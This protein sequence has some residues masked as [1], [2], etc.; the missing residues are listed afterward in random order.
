MLAQCIILSN[1]VFQPARSD[2]TPISPPQCL[3]PACHAAYTRHNMPLECLN[4]SPIFIHKKP[5]IFFSAPVINSILYILCIRNHFVKKCAEYHFHILWLTNPIH[6]Q[7]ALPH[8]LRSQCT[9]SLQLH[10]QFPLAP[11]RLR[12]RSAP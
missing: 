4:G 9:P 3:Y 6:F 2:F 11:C 7:E 5:D 1:T 12:C 10:P 8:P